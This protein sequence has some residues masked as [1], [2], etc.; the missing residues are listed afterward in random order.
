MIGWRWGWCQ[1][2]RKAGADGVME[3]GEFECGRAT[4]VYCILFGCSSGPYVLTPLTRLVHDLGIFSGIPY[5][6]KNAI[7]L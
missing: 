3:K 4:Q 2:S 7:A 6:P 5:P 1:V